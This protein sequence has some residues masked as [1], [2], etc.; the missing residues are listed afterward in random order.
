[1]PSCLTVHQQDLMFLLCSNKKEKTISMIVSMS[2]DIN[3][4]IS[5]NGS[6]GMEGKD[7]EKSKC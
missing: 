4:L 2:H 5:Y 1:M 6:L 7:N 3:N